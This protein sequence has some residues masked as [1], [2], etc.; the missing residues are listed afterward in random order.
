ME[1]YILLLQN[2]LLKFLKS[3][4]TNF[5]SVIDQLNI[6]MLESIRVEK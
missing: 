1:K 4:G 2:S 3:D 6:I 5:V